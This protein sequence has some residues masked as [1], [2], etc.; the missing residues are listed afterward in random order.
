[1]EVI[2]FLHI[3]LHCFVKYPIS[4]FLFRLLLR[5]DNWIHKHKV[6]DRFFQTF[7]EGQQVKPVIAYGA[8]KF[9]PTGRGER[10]VP[11][12]AMR[13]RCANHYK[14]VPVDE[15]R[16]TKCCHRCGSVVQQVYGENGKILRG[17]KRCPSPQ[18]QHRHNGQM[19]RD[20]NAAFNILAC[21]PDLTENDRPAFLRRE[22]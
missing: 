13:K 11:T 12:E 22:G 16:T 9:A 2:Y 18:C 21:Y 20:R 10:A 15:Y 19:S 3:M 6:L 14:V 1:M 17:L 4:N 7:Q 5:I 8:A